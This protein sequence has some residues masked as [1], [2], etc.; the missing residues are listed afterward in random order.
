M[1]EKC[2]LTDVIGIVAKIRIGLN[3]FENICFKL[4]SINILK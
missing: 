3:V 4:L 1:F 2:L